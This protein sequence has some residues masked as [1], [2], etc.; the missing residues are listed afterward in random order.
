MTLVF[1]SDK[2][3]FD[4]EYANDVVLPSEDSHKFQG[5]LNYLNGSVDISGMILHLRNV[6][7]YCRTE[8]GQSRTLF[9]QMNDW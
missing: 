1:C 5:F 8:V 7:Y 3:L 9:L 4:L 2:N 6:S